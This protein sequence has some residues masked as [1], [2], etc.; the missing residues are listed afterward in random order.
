MDQP[1]FFEAEATR[2]LLDRL[3]AESALYHTSKDYMDLLDFVARLRNF[4][5]FNAML[6]QMQKP[7]L[8]HAASARDWHERFGRTVR[9]KA[10]PLIIL[11]PFGPVALVYDLV[12]TDGSKLSEDTAAFPAHG[13]IDSAKILDFF[14]HTQDKGIECRLIDAGDNQAGSIKVIKVSAKKGESLVYQ[15]HI[16]QNHAPPVQFVS[17]VHELGH[18]FLGHLGQDARLNIPARQYLTVAEREIEAESVAY[19]VSS[20]N[21][22]Q[23]KSQAY[24]AD[25]VKKNPTIGSLAVNPVLRAAGQ[26]EATLN[27][28]AHTRF[29]N[30]K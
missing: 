21:G 14:K 12:D 28:T 13:N 2:S 7:G 10:R 1:D 3:L 30:A 6:L 22:V 8:R 4:A 19:I 25:Y 18:L 17:I 5:P 9:E 11:W 20:R 16:N 24:L 23:S 29:G 27:L 15:M 26:V